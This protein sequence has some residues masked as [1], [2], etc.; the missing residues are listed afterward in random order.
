MSSG[1]WCYLW[2]HRPEDF[3]H[4]QHY[5]ENV[6]TCI[7]CSCV[8]KFFVWIVLSVLTC[9]YIYDSYPIHYCYALQ[10]YEC[11]RNVQV[12]NNYCPC[13]HCIQRFCS[14]PY[15]QMFFLML[16]HFNKPTFS[17]CRTAVVILVTALPAGV[18][19]WVFCSTVILFFSIFLI[20]FLFISSS[21]CWGL[22][23]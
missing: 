16:E 1:T 19:G 2:S 10:M 8:S 4:H 22:F 7:H 14:S 18:E 17:F 3:N 12:R 21:S 5:C 20:P 23:F 9:H 6:I 13:I 15:L 11:H